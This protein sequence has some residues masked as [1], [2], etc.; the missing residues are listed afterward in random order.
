MV[1]LSAVGAWEHAGGGQEWS[2]KHHLRHRA[3]VEVRQLRRQLA[4]IMGAALNPLQ[5]PPNA[6]EILALRQILTVCLGDHVGLLEERKEGGWYS[7]EAMEERVTIHKESILYG[8]F[9]TFYYLLLHIGTN[10][11]EYIFIIIPKTNRN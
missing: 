1:L 6:G 3:L 5:K 2:A 9:A 10:Y 11:W 8:E 4:N 7:C